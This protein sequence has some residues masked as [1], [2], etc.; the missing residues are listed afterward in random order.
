MK[1]SFVRVEHGVH[2]LKISKEANITPPYLPQ[3]LLQ[4]EDENEKIEVTVSSD[5]E[6]KH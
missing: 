2:P 1:F 3:D 5:K 6:K 4:R